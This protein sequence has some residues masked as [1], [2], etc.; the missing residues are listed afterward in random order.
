MFSLF[1]KTPQYNRKDDHFEI[2]M[3]IKLA[4]QVVLAVEQ[5]TFQ[6]GL[7][8]KRIALLM[9]DDLLQAYGMDDVPK[10]LID[11]AIEASVR[12][13]KNQTPV[14]KGGYGIQ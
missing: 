12:L 9:V 10:L 13:V 8:K 2:E 6:D 3:V 4:K 14:S 7:E 1:K 11:T 5:T